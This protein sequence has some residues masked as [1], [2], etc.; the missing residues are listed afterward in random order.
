M[1]FEKCSMRLRAIARLRPIKVNDRLPAQMLKVGLQAFD[2]CLLVIDLL[3][4]QAAHMRYQVM[5][6]N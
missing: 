2:Q 1:H 6:V 3:Q 5:S 4:A